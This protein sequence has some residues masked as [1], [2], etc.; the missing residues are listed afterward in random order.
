MEIPDTVMMIGVEF[1]AD[2]WHRD[3]GWASPVWA[4]VNSRPADVTGPADRGEDDD[5]VVWAGLRCWAAPLFVWACV[6]LGPAD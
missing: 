5:C 3:V 4:D 1:G 2:R 6:R